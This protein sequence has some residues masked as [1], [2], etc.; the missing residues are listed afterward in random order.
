MLQIWSFNLLIK[1]IIL[2]PVSHYFLTKE[3]YLCIFTSLYQPP[4]RCSYEMLNS[5]TFLRGEMKWKFGSHAGW[6]LEMLLSIMSFSGKPINIGPKSYIIGQEQFLSLD[7]TDVWTTWKMIDL[8]SILQSQ[9]L[10]R[11]LS[12]TWRKSGA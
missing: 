3:M 9:S 11:W 12:A 1:A 6:C 2:S 5:N 10:M 8:Q 7:A 4:K